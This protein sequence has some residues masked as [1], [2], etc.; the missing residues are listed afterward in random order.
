MAAGE[1]CLTASVRSGR[2]RPW[3]EAACS[4]P[5]GTPRCE[6][7]PLPSLAAFWRLRSRHGKSGQT[8]QL[9]SLPRR[10]PVS[11]SAPHTRAPLGW[12][13]TKPIRGLLRNLMRSRC[14]WFRSTWP[15]RS[16]RPLR[17][18]E[19]SRAAF[20]LSERRRT[21]G[22]EVHHAAAWASA[23]C[24]SRTDSAVA[25]EPPCSGILGSRLYT[26]RR[27]LR[28]GEGLAWPR[29]DS[30]GPCS[31]PN[32]TNLRQTLLP[33]T[34]PMTVDAIILLTASAILFTFPLWVPLLKRLRKSDHS[35]G[36]S[37][38]MTTPD[39]SSGEDRPVNA[40]SERAEKGRPT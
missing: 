39:R 19:R 28:V 24:I 9:I 30:R 5:S 11:V 10:P 33:S 35:S 21:S 8:H 4:P 20:A 25:A 18:L 17:C 29:L 38:G 3:L 40:K 13:R 12:R 22:P 37:S 26:D 31:R 7:W 2:Y 1:L 32:N 14:G 15:P 16:S 27:A 6:C 23:P 34:H 36:N